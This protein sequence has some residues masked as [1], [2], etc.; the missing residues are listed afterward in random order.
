MSKRNIPPAAIASL[1]ILGAIAILL[2][3]MSI[4]VGKAQA[5]DLTQQ[6]TIKLNSG[7]R[8]PER[9]RADRLLERGKTQA[10]EGDIA[11]AI[12]SWRTAQQLYQQLGDMDGQGIA[13]RYLATAYSQQG[14][15]RAQEDALRRRLAVTRDQQDFNGQMLANNDLGRV[16]APRAGGTV[17]AG[18]LFMEAMDV[19]SSVRNQQGEILTA[20]NLSWLANS[21]EQPEQ[22]ARIVEMAT[23]PV[24]QW[25]ANPVSLG[26]KLHDRADQRLNQQRYYSSTRFNTAAEQLAAEENYL[27]QFLAINDLVLAYRAMGRYDLA[28]DWL[29]EQLQL[30]RSLND[31]QQELATLTALGDL[32]LEVGRTTLAQRYF[33]Q[34]LGVAEGLDDPQQT[35][36]LRERL[37]SFEQP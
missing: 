26:L 28:R 4:P 23:L 18:E 6:M 36:L 21:L 12:V 37:A 20:T 2:A 33:E 29:D 17:A 31:T 15:L 25:Y 16:L 32:N 13:Y 34:A 9:D 35:G 5:T 3:A 7:T 24:L 8:S 27:V 11:A 22:N 10:A 30:A 14:D 19:A 1:P